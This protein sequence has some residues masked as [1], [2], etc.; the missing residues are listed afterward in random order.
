MF[1]TGKNFVDIQWMIKRIENMDQLFVRRIKWNQNID[2]WMN[3][4]WI[5]NAA[6]I[7]LMTKRFWSILGNYSK[8]YLI[9][10]MSSARFNGQSFILLS[11]G[12]RKIININ[13]NISSSRWKNCLLSERRIEFHVC[14][15]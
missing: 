8:I 2:Q 3:T 6:S 9:R 7:N 15:G 4:K 10:K 11:N 1:I 13:W 14:S 5:E 12:S